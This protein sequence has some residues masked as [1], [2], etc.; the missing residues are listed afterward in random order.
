M[1]WEYEVAEF[2][3]TGGREALRVALKTDRGE[4]WELVTVLLHDASFLAVYKRRNMRERPE[5]RLVDHSY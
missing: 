3:A 4:G 5:E 1:Q 2:A